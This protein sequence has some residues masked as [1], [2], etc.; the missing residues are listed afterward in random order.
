MELEFQISVV[1]PCL[2]VA[3]YIEECIGSVD[4]QTYQPKE[5]I[6]VDNGSE[7]G[8]PEVLK[9]LAKRYPLIK[10]FTQPRQ[11]ANAARNLG[12]HLAGGEWIQFLDADDLLEPDKLLLFLIDVW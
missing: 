6:C 12:L 1:I 2:N 10:N 11:G 9:R 3:Q 4:K 8:T 7:D 5:I